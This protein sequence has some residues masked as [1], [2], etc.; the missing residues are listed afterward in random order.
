MKLCVGPCINDIEN[1][2]Y[3]NIKKQ[4][5][6]FFDGKKQIIKNLVL[7]EKKEVKLLNFEQAQKY[8]VLIESIKHIKNFESIIM[9]SQNEENID[10]I[11]IYEKNSI[12]SLIIHRYR[13]NVLFEC[14]KYIEEYYDNLL[15]DSISSL[16]NL[17]YLENKNKPKKIYSSFI[18]FSLIPL[19]LPKKSKYSKIVENANEN[20][21]SHFQSNYLVFQKLKERTRDAL[22]ELE[23]ILNISNINL[24]HSFD[25]SNFFEND[26]VGAMIVLENGEFNKKLYRKF[27]IKNVEIKG[28]Y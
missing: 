2:F 24:I 3:E 10:V 19:F 4:V 14:S 7:K 26:K 25:I 23:E 15:E 17:Y 12:F 18:F 27:I 22:K 8:K 21:K 11:G 5:Q 13:K 1:S 16:L 20:A 9:L 6:Q 28:D